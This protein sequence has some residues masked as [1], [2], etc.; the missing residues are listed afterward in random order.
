MIGDRADHCREC[1]LITEHTRSDCI[2]YLGQI[3]VQCVFAVEVIV[4]K[5]LDVFGKVTEEEYVLI[6]SFTSDFNL[7]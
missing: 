3:R 2:K 7:I 6:T 1:I 5:V 4:A